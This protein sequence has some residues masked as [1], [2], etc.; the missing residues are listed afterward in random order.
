MMKSSDPY[1]DDLRSRFQSLRSA[2]KRDAPPFLA[3]LA[4]ARCRKPLSVD[5]KRLVWG[6]G[7]L[8]AAAALALVLLPDSSEEG[9]PRSLAKAIPTLLPPDSEGIVLLPGPLISEATVPSDI[10]LPLSSRFPL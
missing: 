1:D 7:L 6:T 4:A 5:S 8:A 9:P 3:T 2:E 10:L